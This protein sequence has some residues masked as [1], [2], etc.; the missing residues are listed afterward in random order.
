MP[1]RQTQTQTEKVKSVMQSINNEQELQDRLS[2]LRDQK[3]TILKNPDK[4]LHDDVRKMA[5]ESKS[6]SAPKPEF[7]Q[8]ARV[9]FL[10]EQARKLLG[11]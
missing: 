1:E 11:K 3:E 8:Q 10:R 5:R 2:L 9:D 7:D 6:S 4:A